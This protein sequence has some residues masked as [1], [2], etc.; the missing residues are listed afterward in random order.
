MDK[1]WKELLKYI[2]DKKCYKGVDFSLCEE[3]PIVEDF[4]EVNEAEIR[5]RYE[6]EEIA[7]KFKEMGL[8][9]VED[10]DDENEIHFGSFEELNDISQQEYQQGLAWRN[11]I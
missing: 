7:E 8:T 5:A 2:L 10:D 3:Q 1:W 4:E 11:D 9:S 6:L